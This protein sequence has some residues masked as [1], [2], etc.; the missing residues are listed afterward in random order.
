[1]RLRKSRAL[2]CALLAACAATFGVGVARV[3]AQGGAEP[4]AAGAEFVSAAEL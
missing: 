3:G 4:K 1:M 2:A